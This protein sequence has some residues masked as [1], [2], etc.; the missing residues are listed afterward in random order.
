MPAAL[1]LKEKNS[2]VVNQAVR[3]LQNGRDN[4]SGV[5]TLATGASTTTVKAVNCSPTSSVL[6]F[7]ATAHAAAEVTTT[8]VLQANIGKA[9]F[10]ISHANNAVADRT[11][12]WRVCGGS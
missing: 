11:W 5:V 10:I 3:E 12:Y 6:M 9:Q 4:A 1:S 7:P 2:D 8:Y